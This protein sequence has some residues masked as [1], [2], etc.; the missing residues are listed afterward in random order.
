MSTFPFCGSESECCQSRCEYARIGNVTTAVWW[1]GLLSPSGPGGA[2]KCHRYFHTTSPS[3]EAS[4]C[5]TERWRENTKII[6]STSFY[7]S[8]FL[9]S[10]ESRLNCSSW[11]SIL[12]KTTT[13]LCSEA[14]WTSTQGRLLALQDRS[15]PVC[16]ELPVGWFWN[17]PVCS[18]LTAWINIGSVHFCKP[19]ICS[20]FAILHVANFKFLQLAIDNLTYHSEVDT[21]WTVWWL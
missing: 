20:N 13:K 18:N 7:S 16:M 10:G 9:W 2:L 5:E 6:Q 11:L 3:C 17:H 19:C 12:N 15:G 14:H 8:I 21:D 4:K 1:Q